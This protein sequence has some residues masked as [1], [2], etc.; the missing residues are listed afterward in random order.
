MTDFRTI[1]HPYRRLA[2]T[3]RWV[4]RTSFP[5]PMVRGLLARVHEKD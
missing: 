3:R 4:G 5:G 2:R 1:S